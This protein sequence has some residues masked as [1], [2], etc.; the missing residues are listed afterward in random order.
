MMHVEELN[1]EG[2]SH[3]S[4]GE[5]ETAVE[6]FDKA[7]KLDPSIV[8]AWSNRGLALSK[9][10]RYDEAI[11]S[12]DQAIELFPKYTAAWVDKGVALQELGRLD[13]ALK[14]YDMAIEMSPKVHFKITGI[15]IFTRSS[16]L[17]KICRLYDDT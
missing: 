15:G 13:E 12:Y 14:C 9:L 7:L 6:F 11:E 5:F 10:G 17:S 4:Q 16:Q 3:H 8:A 2:V 1:D